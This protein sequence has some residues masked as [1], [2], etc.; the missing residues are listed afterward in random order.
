MPDTVH[1]LRIALLA[2]I[3]LAE[4][5]IPIEACPYDEYGKQEPAVE[6]TF[7]GHARVEERLRYRQ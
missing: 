3:L 1:I 2:S 5:I 4:N 7:D 6:V